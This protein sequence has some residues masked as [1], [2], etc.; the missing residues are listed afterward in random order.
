MR[1]SREEICNGCAHLDFKNKYCRRNPNAYK[2]LQTFT[3][4]EGFIAVF[5]EPTCGREYFRAPGAPDRSPQKK[6]KER[7]E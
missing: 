3:N 1:I 4:V 7:A 6:S 2:V 5:P